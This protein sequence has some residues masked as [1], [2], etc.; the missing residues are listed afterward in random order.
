[1]I[2]SINTFKIKK[3]LKNNESLARI[4][5]FVFLTAETNAKLEWQPLD[6]MLSFSLKEIHTGQPLIKTMDNV[7]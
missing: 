3:L 6:T 2:N 1:V 4:V 7:N 5:N